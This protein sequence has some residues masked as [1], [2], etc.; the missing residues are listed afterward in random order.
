MRARYQLNK[1]DSDTSLKIVDLLKKSPLVEGKAVIRDLIK[2]DGLRD[3]TTRT[4]GQLIPIKTL[5][6]F[7]ETMLLG[8][9]QSTFQVGASLNLQLNEVKPLLY[10]ILKMSLA[11][12]DDQFEDSHLITKLDDFLKIDKNQ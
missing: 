1:P 10:A 8:R 12:N 6:C 7:Y 3:W 2:Y 9:L 11:M 4:G 5:D